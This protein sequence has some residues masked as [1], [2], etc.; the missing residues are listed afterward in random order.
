MTSTNSS[1]TLNGLT[2]TYKG[3][4]V[5]DAKTEKRVEVMIPPFT[6]S[7]YDLFLAIF[8]LFIYISTNLFIYIKQLEAKHP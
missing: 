8:H 2:C 4:E 3:H 7:Y 6:L 5:T 1:P